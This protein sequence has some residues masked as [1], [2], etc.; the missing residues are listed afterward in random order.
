MTTKYGYMK[1]MKKGIEVCTVLF[2]IFMMTVPRASVAS[3]ADKERSPRIVIIEFHGMKEGIIRD[4][5]ENL[6]HFREMLM[7]RSNDHSY[8]H[9]PRVLVTMPA[10]S[11]PG[12]TAMY[13]GRHPKHTGVVSTIWFDRGSHEVR[14]MIS[15]GQQRINTI[16]RKQKVATL[17]DLAGAAGRRSMTAMLM[18]T[19]GVDWPLRSGAFFWGNAS[20]MGLLEKGFWFPS[21]SYIDERTVM[22]FEDGHLFNFNK[23]I[24]GIAKYGGEIPHIM[25]LQLLGMDLYSH[26][27]PNELISSHAT[28][29]EI[30][31]RYAETVL[32]PLMGRLMAT[33]K[34]VGCYDDTVFILVSEHGFTKIESF[35]A[36]ALVDDSLRQEFRLPNGGMGGG[37]ADAVI[38]PGASTKEVYI[39]NRET[40]RW[41]DPPR[42][43]SDVKPAVDLL[44][45]NSEIV[46]H[47]NALVVRQYP[48]ERNEGV[49]ENDRWWYF[50][51][52]GYASNTGD[53][54]GFMR[55]LKPLAMLSDRFDLQGYVVDGL[56]NQY[57]RMT[58]PDIK[59][60]NRRGSYFEKDRRKY[61]HHGSYYHSDSV[62][63]FWVGGAGLKRILPGRHIVRRDLS[64]RD[65]VPLVLSLLEIP[66]PEGLDG[67]NPLQY[68]SA[69]QD[70]GP[71]R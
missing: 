71:N 51:C 19:N 47:M 64:T 25:V 30:Q 18:V 58:A 39:K 36:D 17:F 14:T 7:G 29:S 1:G 2:C 26:Y 50:D 31:T 43:L 11:I 66:V 70:D 9:F 67:I 62:V 49:E 40:G 34:D 20:V 15:Y 10:A 33:L 13:T 60:I 27:P 56:R 24:R 8:V 35:L 45:D 22:A 46:E 61:G 23:S 69:V 55:A 32:D 4:G 63:S 54:A 57:T 59:I 12:I 5:L 68:V 21:S 38:M 28:M 42:L 3:T 44:L 52:D 48:G 41:L 16:L 65:L 37:D 6:P 53:T